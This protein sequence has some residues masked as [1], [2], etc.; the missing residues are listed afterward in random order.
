ME[1]HQDSREFPPRLRCDDDLPA[2][3]TRRHDDDPLLVATPTTVTGLFQGQTEPGP[4]PDRQ[5]A[6]P[7]REQALVHRRDTQRSRRRDRQLRLIRQ[8]LKVGADTSS[9]TCSPLRYR[10]PPEWLPTK[11]AR[12]S[13]RRRPLAHLATSPGTVRII[14]HILSL[15]GC[16]W[17]RQLVPIPP[18]RQ[19]KGQDL[20][21][22][23]LGG[24][25]VSA[26]TRRD[27]PL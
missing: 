21:G 7:A 6:I 25:A 12:H 16:W 18:C 23:P 3:T 11:A 1:E 20:T 9:K 4:R 19:L 15:R 5:W 17:R 22:S 2:T 27:P 8:G 24:H 13:K 10:W 26:P 14:I